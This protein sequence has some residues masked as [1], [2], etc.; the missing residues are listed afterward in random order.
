MSKKSI[1]ITI[2]CH[3]PFIRHL[4]DEHV[5]KNTALFQAISDTYLPLLN[6]FADLE[7]EGI[8]FKEAINMFKEW[9]GNDFEFM[10]WGPADIYMLEDNLHLPSLW[11]IHPQ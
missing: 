10:T 1:A 4:D 5:S 11:Y 7:A 2:N 3:K 8:P 9:C 6:M